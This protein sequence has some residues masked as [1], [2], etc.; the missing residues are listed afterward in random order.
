MFQVGFRSVQVDLN[1]LKWRKP[2]AV[3]NVLWG[4]CFCFRSVKVAFKVDL[5]G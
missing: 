1:R 3:C 2:Y 4:G 5:K